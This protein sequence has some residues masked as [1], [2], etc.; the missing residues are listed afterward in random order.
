MLQFHG[1]NR[2][3]SS[4]RGSIG[5]YGLLLGLL[6]GWFVA[7]QVLNTSNMCGMPACGTSGY[8]SVCVAQRSL[9]NGVSIY[10]PVEEMRSEGAGL[11]SPAG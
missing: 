3:N 10:K 6:G 9:D 7:C 4:H 1:Y 11:G 8:S 5:A 2:G